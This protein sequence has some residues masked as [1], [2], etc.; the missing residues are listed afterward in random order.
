MQSNCLREAVSSS[1]AGSGRLGGRPFAKRLLATIALVASGL[2]LRA[3][4][5]PAPARGQRLIEV[6]RAAEGERISCMR[7]TQNG[8]APTRDGAL[9]VAVARARPVAGATGFT[10]AV[11]L[12]RSDD[13]GFTWRRAAEVPTPGAGDATLVP[14]GEL[15]SCL[16]SASDGQPFSS[17]F[18][19]RYDPRTDRWVGAPVAIERGSGSDDHYSASDLVRTA[20]GALVAVIGNGGAVRAPAWNCSWSS[21]MRCLPAGS[22]RAAPHDGQKPRP[23]HEN[24]TTSSCPQSSQCTRAKPCAS[25]PHRRNAAT[26]RTQRTAAATALLPPPSAGT[27]PTRPAPPGTAPRPPA[28]AAPVRHRRFARKLRGTGT[29]CGGIAPRLPSCR[30]FQPRRPRARA[31]AAPNPAPPAEPSH[32]PGC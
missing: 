9:F 7:A 23:L 32:H 10:V 17:V 8:A 3:Q 24:A 21:G 25:T 30:P 12:W 2:P 1:V 26:S 20:G 27:A 22:M 29:R 4:T 31:R 18:W 13:G 11:E 6:T 5:L 14:D 19:Q 16:W 28:R 15:L